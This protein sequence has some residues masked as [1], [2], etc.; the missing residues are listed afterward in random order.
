VEIDQAYRGRVT[1]PPTPLP[2][3]DQK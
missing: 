2:V 3:L 1:R